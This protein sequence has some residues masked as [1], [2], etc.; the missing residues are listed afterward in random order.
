MKNKDIKRHF[1]RK[2]QRGWREY[3]TV[4]I[5]L[6]ALGYSERDLPNLKRVCELMECVPAERDNWV[7]TYYLK[8]PLKS[9]EDAFLGVKLEIAE[10]TGKTL[11]EAVTYASRYLETD[12]NTIKERMKYIATPFGFRVFTAVGEEGVVNDKWKERGLPYWVDKN[13]VLSCLYDIPELLDMFVNDAQIQQNFRTTR[14]NS[15]LGQLGKLG[16]YTKSDFFEYSDGHLHL[17]YAIRYPE[18]VE[19]FLKD[20]VKLIKEFKHI[21]I[22]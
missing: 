13:S 8:D 18:N 19:P 9:A 17:T 20:L 12:E 7:G 15:L 3:L 6:K 11:E 1:R 14:D 4:S 16:R 2:I 10:F 21:K 5:P 22:K